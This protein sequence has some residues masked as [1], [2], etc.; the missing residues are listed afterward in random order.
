MTNGHDRGMSGFGPATKN[1]GVM[2][3]PICVGLAVLSVLR[4]LAYG[5]LLWLVL[6]RQAEDFPAQVVFKIFT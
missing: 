2:H 6:A 4:V 3:C 1:L 5:S